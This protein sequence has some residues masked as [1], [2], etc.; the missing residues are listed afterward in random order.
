MRDF[1]T[2]SIPKNK[3][4]A[5]AGGAYDFFGLNFAILRKFLLKP[6]IPATPEA[7]LFFFSMKGMYD[8]MN[9][10]WNADVTERPTFT[11]LRKL[12]DL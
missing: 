6:Q 9:A 2:N 5:E 11:E 1:L 10:C 3:N 7:E 4:V 8:V 12:L